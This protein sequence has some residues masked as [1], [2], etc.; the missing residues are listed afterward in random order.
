MQEGHIYEVGYTDP[1]GQVVFE[2]ASAV[3][4]AYINVTVTKHNFIPHFGAIVVHDSNA[5]VSLSHESAL[6][7]ELVT[8]GYSGFPGNSYLSI[9]FSIDNAE[10]VLLA[11]NLTT[12]PPQYNW[13]VVPGLFTT[14][15]FV[16]L[17]I[18][19]YT[20]GATAVEQY[21][22]A[23][24]CFQV[25]LAADGPDPYIYSQDDPSTWPDPTGVAVWD[26]PDIKIYRD[27]IEYPSLE[28]GESNSIEVTVHNKGNDMNINGLVTL[29]YAPFGGGVTWHWIGEAE[30]NV[31]H[32]QTETVIFTF[33]PELG[34]SVCL[35]VDL[36]HDD[37]RSWNKINNIG[38]ENI[39]VIEMHS[40]GSET[41]HIG[42]PLNISGYLSIRVTQLGEHADVWKAIIIG[43][44]SQFLA[45]GGTLSITLLVDSLHLL[46][47]AEWRLFE[48]EI[49][50]K[51]RKVGGMVLNATVTNWFERCGILC[52][53]II[54][55]IIV[56]AAYVIVKRRQ[57]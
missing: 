20:L 43:Y 8:I 15:Q 36:D 50:F 5:Q 24:N 10:Q 32:Q 55:L 40:P 21:P 53:I 4:P 11:Q 48:V 16:N 27:G 25:I 9:Y 47:T 12:S 26:N 34:Q 57:K 13:P 49:F 54:G 45:A 2:L 30:M 23:V 52:W 42:N 14:T 3:T 35:R 38:Y 29:S 28:L 31:D 37:E 19:N 51:C 18:V 17:W 7:N 56:A 46:D 44:A 22:A 1:R 41:I 33:T 39:D 6:D